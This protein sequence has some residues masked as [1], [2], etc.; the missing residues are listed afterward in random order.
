MGEH[1]TR[2]A[3]SPTGALH[4]GNARTFLINHLLAVANG[5]RVLMRVEDLDG[6][7]VKA[8]A[9]ARMLETLRWLGLR[10]DDP[11]LR[12]SERAD[13]Y[14]AAL[15]RL[16]DTGDA[17]PCVCSR[18]DIETAA[19]APHADDGVKTYPGTCRGRFAS[20]DEAAATGRPVAWRVRAVGGPV[21]FG[22]RFAGPQEFDLA[23]HG[24]DFVVVKNDGL[25]AYQLAVTVDD[26]EAGVDAVVRGDDLLDSAAR[27][28]QLRRMLGLTPEPA[29]WHLPLVVGPDGR[30]LAKRH[31][32]TRIDRYRR[33]GV[34]PRRVL[35][36][37]GFWSGLL[38]ERR[39]ADMNELAGRFDIG[40]L[41]RRA[42]V[43]GEEDDGFLLGG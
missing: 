38:T 2:L 19:S 13:R 25:A 39:P 42:V 43:L 18:K 14:A 29:Y 26:A 22:D 17:Y 5:W 35:G 12:Q 7:R 10:W 36:L 16:I 6:P 23:A 1:V 31:G 11:L 3:P 34:A 33:A 28:I 40:L 15:H 27:Q 30:R 24:G 21:A 4:L 9:E 37:L 8:G 32:D 20:V 41:P